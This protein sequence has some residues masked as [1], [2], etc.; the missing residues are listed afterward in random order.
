MA[1]ITGIAVAWSREFYNS[2][3]YLFF[4]L[5]MR[6]KTLLWVTIGFCVL[7]LIYPEGVP[8]GVAAPFGGVVAG[9][10]FSGSP[11]LARSAW[12]HL[13]LAVLRRRATGTRVDDLL[14]VKPARRARPG[15]PP[16]RVVGGSE[17]APKKQAAPKDKRYLN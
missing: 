10:L 9:L 7:D 11:S 8:E 14:S 2:T 16:L 5:P 12:L 17:E 13:R 1:I 15:G 6:G 4:V 3:V